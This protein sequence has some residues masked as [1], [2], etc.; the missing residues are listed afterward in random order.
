MTATQDLDEKIRLGK[1]ILASQ[2]DNL[3]VI[4]TVGEVPLPM[5]RSNK[6]RNFPERG[7][8]DWSIGSWTGPQHPS[9]FYLVQESVALRW[10][11]KAFALS[12]ACA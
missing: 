3:W 5:P 10:R 11:S 1:A 6:L 4:G 12:A 9:Q 7:G 8:H 2:A